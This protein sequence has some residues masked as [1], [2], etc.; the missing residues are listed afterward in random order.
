ML[1][2]GVFDCLHDGHR[3][4]LREARKLGN[5]LTVVVAED[6]SA[7]NLKNRLPKQNA[8]E[9]Q[10]IILTEGLADE[11]VIGDKIK[12]SWEVLKKHRP[13]I[14]AFGY[15]QTQL[16]EAIHKAMEEFDFS[17]SFSEISAFEPER[18]H[19]SI[20]DRIIPR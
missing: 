12:G 4:F 11:V 19:T 13:R 8:S 16:K 7:K 6:S 20:L 3:H 9:R 18:L 10:V 15:D 2:F 14:I 1:V 5:C 17:L